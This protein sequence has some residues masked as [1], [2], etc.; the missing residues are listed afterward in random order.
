VSKPS[1]RNHQLIFHRFL[2]VSGVVAKDVVVRYAVQDAQEAAVVNPEL[3]N[4]M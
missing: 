2:G 1:K 4:A 3:Q